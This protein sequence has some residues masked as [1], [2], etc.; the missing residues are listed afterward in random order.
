MYLSNDKSPI[1]YQLFACTQ[2][3]SFKYRYDC[4][5]DS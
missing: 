4:A 1:E 5:Y 3:N 2:L